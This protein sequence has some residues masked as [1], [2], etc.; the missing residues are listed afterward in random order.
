M[1]HKNIFYPVEHYL[2]TNIL[3]IQSATFWSASTT[4]FIAVYGKAIG[5]EGGLGLFFTL[6]A[7]GMAVSRI[8]S[9]RQVDKGRITQVIAI[10]L[11]LVCICFFALSGCAVFSEWNPEV[12][13][14]IFFSVALFLGIGFGSMFPAFNT[15][16]VNLA[17]NS[18][19]GTATSTYLTSWD[20]GIGLGLTLGGYIGELTNFQTVYFFGA[21]LVVIST[22][23]FIFRITPYYHRNKLR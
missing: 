9:G 16:F 15:M 21:C 11:C 19:R 4:T 7:I 17:P 14:Y 6:M 5:I 2:I 10:G 22:F 8:F 1:F 20:I 13:K 23:Y 3:Q 12:G 18:Q